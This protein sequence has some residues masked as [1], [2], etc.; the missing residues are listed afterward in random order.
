MF[1]AALNKAQS[2]LTHPL[3]NGIHNANHAYV[4]KG[5]HFKRMM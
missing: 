5:G 2:K 1:G 3:T 4:P